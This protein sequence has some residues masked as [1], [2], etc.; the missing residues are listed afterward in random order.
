MSGGAGPGEI[1]RELNDRGALTVSGKS[2]QPYAVRS[3]LASRWLW[4]FGEGGGS[5]CY[6]PG[7]FGVGRASAGRRRRSLSGV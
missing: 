2:W 7:F 4:G 5:H 6:T 1:A 3:V